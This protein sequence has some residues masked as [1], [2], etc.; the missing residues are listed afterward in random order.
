MEWYAFIEDFNGRTI[1]KF[2]IFNH[3]AFREDC[4]KN[5]KK[6]KDDKEKFLEEVRRDLMYYF[7]SKAEYEIILTSMF[8]SPHHRFKSEKIDVYDQVMMNWPAFAEYIWQN[9]TK[10]AKIQ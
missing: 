1:E 8:E 10:I 4:K 2:N 3:H 5:A 7:W 9:R 6:Y